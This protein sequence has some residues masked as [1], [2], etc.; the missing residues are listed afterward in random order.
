MSKFLVHVFLEECDGPDFHDIDYTL[1][2][3]F[4]TQEE[5]EEFRDEIAEQYGE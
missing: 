1:L 4:D 5:A 2:R 3:E